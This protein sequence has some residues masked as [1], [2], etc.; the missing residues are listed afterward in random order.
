[1]GLGDFLRT[2]PE[3]RGRVVLIQIGA[4]TRAGA[5]DYEEL[6]REELDLIDQAAARAAGHEDAAP[7]ELGKQFGIVTF[8]LIGVKNISAAAA[9]AKHGADL[10]IKENDKKALGKEKIDDKIFE[11]ERRLLIKRRG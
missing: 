10:F 8:Q 3:W 6:R 1:M 4:P 7:G 2:R 11:I 9:F 5:S